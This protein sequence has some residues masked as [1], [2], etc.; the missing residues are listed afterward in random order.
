M[1]KHS[2]LKRFFVSILLPLVVLCAV[3]PVKGQHMEEEILFYTNKFRATKGLAPLQSDNNIDRAAEKHS[4]AMANGRLPFGHQGFEE[5]IAGI[6]R[7]RGAVKAAAENVAYGQKSAE[8]VV[9]TWIKS[10]P[11]RKNMLGNYTRAGI[12]VAGGKRN[13]LYFTQIFIR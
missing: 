13:T 12:G 11:H 4:R 6:A 2:F 7:Q 5:R 1:S 9:N 8:E 3:T 10:P